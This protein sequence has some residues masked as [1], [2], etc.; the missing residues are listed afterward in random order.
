MQSSKL[1]Q[2]VLNDGFIYTGTLRL[3]NGRSMSRGGWGWCAGELCHP[4]LHVVNCSLKFVHEILK[5]LHTL[6]QVLEVTLVRKRHL[7][8]L[9]MS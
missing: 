1:G 6:C 3:N 8:S 4:D 2:E 5:S 9:G 7:L